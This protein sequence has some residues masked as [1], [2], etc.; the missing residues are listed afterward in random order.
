MC[1]R[2][3]RSFDGWELAYLLKCGGVDI[4]AKVGET[5]RGSI[6]GLRRVL[7]GGCSRIAI[8][9]QMAQNW[10]EAGLR[11]NLQ[12]NSCERSR[13]RDTAISPGH[14]EVCLRMRFQALLPLLLLGQAP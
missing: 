6:F 1:I 5:G 12:R 14:A 3:R 11:S 9:F 7:A 10:R 2:D 8:I 13:T 4:F